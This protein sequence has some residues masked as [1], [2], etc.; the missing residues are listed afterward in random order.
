MVKNP[1]LM[2]AARAHY[3]V[4]IVGSEAYACRIDDVERVVRRA[5]AP[6]EPSLDGAPAWEA[7]RL[8][9]VEQA[10]DMKIPIISLRTL[11]GMPDA[12]QPTGKEALLVVRIQGQPYALLVEACLSVVAG[13]A[14][15]ADG[16]HLTPAL[17]GPRGS[18]FQRVIAWQKFLL[19]TL[20]LDKLLQTE[21]PT[22]QTGAPDPKSH[23]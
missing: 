19:V 23:L 18:A 13:F 21:S 22:V 7:G 10:D 8:A 3:L 16:F 14:N 5:D 20:Q 4:F 17:L 2:A 9:G 15:E 1:G 11:W 6:V 12:E